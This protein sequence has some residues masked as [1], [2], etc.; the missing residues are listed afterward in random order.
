MQAFLIDRGG[1]LDTGDNRARSHPAQV[2]QDF[3]YSQQPGSRQQLHY[4]LVPLPLGVVLIKYVAQQFVPGYPAQVP[5]DFLRG[6]QPDGFQQIDYLFVLLPLG[7]VGVRGS[8][9]RVRSRSATRSPAPAALHWHPCPPPCWF[10]FT[11]AMADLLRLGRSPRSYRLT[12]FSAHRQIPDQDSTKE[13]W[14]RLDS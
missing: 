1:I 8:P 4:A 11:P 12:A 2:A 14:M 7:V 9:D 5:Q 6:Q 10:P 13:C 3:F